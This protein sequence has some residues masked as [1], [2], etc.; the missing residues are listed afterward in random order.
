MMP[1]L[2]LRHVPSIQYN[3]CELCKHYCVPFFLGCV[4]L[5]HRDPKW[6]RGRGGR[7]NASLVP[8]DRVKLTNEGSL[9]LSFLL[10]SICPKLE[11]LEEGEG[12]R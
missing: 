4:Y 9:S 12:K 3:T 11:G 2:S 6:R 8:M 5:E 1:L 7:N 10:N